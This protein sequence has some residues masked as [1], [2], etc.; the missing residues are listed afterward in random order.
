MLVEWKGAERMIQRSWSHGFLSH[1]S[2]PWGE[3]EDEHGDSERERER[4][5]DKKRNRDIGREK[6]VKQLVLLPPLR[7]VWY[8]EIVLCVVGPIKGRRAERSDF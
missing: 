4:E 2:C 8:W 1:S 5:R 7:E 6:W 3:E